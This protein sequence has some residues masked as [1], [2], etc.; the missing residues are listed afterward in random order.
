MVGTG[1]LVRADIYG[2]ENSNIHIRTI[3]QQVVCSDG[4]GYI[5]PRGLYEGH[6][7]RSGDVLQNETK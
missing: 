7:L 5:G 4:S 1:K 3:I 6:S 2:R